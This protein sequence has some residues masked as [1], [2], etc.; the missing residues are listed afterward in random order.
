MNKAP[1][2]QGFEST[3]IVSRAAQILK[4]TRKPRY[5]RLLGIGSISIIHVY[6]FVLN[7]FNRD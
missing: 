1:H 4:R 7:L 5:K 6:I 2:E 3:S